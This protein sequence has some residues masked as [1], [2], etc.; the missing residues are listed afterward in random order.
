MTK[1]TLTDYKLY[2]ENGMLY[3][4]LTYTVEDDHRIKEVIIPRVST[5]IITCSNHAPV[6]NREA[7]FRSAD[8]D[9]VRLSSEGMMYRLLKGYT[10]HAPMPVYFVERVI[11]DKPT[12]MTVEEIE[13]KL[14]Y[15]V[16]II[17]K[18]EN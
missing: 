16:K 13:K 10:D 2:K 6:I 9:E 18:K 15:K 5:G 12:E 17:S 8:Y 7:D 14:G 11:E 3:M 4:S 1:S